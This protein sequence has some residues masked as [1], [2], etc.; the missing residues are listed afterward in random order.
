MRLWWNDYIWDRNHLRIWQ[1]VPLQP[2]LQWQVFGP[3]HS[4]PFKHFCRQTAGGT[5]TDRETRLKPVGHIIKGV[6]TI[7][8]IPVKYYIITERIMFKD[9]IN[10]SGKVDRV[11]GVT[12][13]RGHCCD[14]WVS[15]VKWNFLHFNLLTWG[16]EVTSRS[17]SGWGL[18]LTFITSLSPPAWCTVT[19]IRSDASSSIHTHWLTHTCG[20]T[21]R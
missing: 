20:E 12:G 15:S 7:I 16:K 19:H 3:T 17:F 14:W 4:P 2:G 5:E 9:T 10:S 11:L 13:V 1:R 6:T 8:L 18:V 21:G